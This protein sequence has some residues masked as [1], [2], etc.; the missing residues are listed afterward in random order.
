M[1]D[2]IE[3]FGRSKLMK[4]GDN[5]SKIKGE[6]LVDQHILRCRLPGPAT[7]SRIE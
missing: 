3:L 5:A 1:D 7:R 2:T 4:S 6:V